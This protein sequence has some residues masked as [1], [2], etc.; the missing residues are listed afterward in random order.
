M[1]DQMSRVQPI[2]YDATRKMG[3]PRQGALSEFERY[4][5]AQTNVRNL[6]S[7]RH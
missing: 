3:L 5:Y 4:T 2:A 1:Y 6:R 7:D